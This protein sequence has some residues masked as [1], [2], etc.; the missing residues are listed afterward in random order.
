MRRGLNDLLKNQKAILSDLLDKL[1]GDSRVYL[2]AARPEVKYEAALHDCFQHCK[3]R[4]EVILEFKFF[5]EGC[6]R[7][8]GPAKAKNG[9]ILLSSPPLWHIA[10]WDELY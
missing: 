7:I 4:H 9:E 6:W 8:T 2:L 5:D 10:Y 3:N 1:G